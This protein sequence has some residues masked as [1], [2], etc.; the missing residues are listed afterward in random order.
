MDMEVL[1]PTKS[2]AQKAPVPQNI[3]QPVQWQMY[4]FIENIAENRN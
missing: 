2:V 3:T 1:S 4:Q